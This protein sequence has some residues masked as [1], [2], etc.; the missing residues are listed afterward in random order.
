MIDRLFGKK[1]ALL[2][3]FIVGHFFVVAGCDIHH[4]HEGAHIH[5]N[6]VI[7]VSVEESGTGYIEFEAPSMDLWGFG[8]HPEER[9]DIDRQNAILDIFKREPSRL[10]SFSPENGCRLILEEVKVVYSDEDEKHQSDDTHF[11]HSE[12]SELYARY[13]IECEK[14]IADRELM[15]RLDHEFPAIKRI[16]AVIL[17]EEGQ[18]SQEISDGKG[19]IEL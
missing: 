2:T 9:S 5:G 1:I 16:K 17:S 8:H 15:I 19:R 13:R 4:E 10:F 7:R 11:E 12:H 6:A 3:I 14:N 18:R